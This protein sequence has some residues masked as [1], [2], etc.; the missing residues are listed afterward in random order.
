MVAW[1]K[2]E[3][4]DGWP[5]V[6]VKRFKGECPATYETRAEM[7]RRIIEGFRIGEFVGQLAD[8]MENNLV[9]LQSPQEAKTGRE[10]AG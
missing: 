2:D 8:D 10:Q 3:S 7:I 1:K 4:M 9:S 5:R 6:K